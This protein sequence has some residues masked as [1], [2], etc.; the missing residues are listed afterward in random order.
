LDDQDTIQEQ[1]ETVFS[2][3]GCPRQMMLLA[4]VEAG[5]GEATLF[6]SLPSPSLLSAFEGFKQIGPNEL[7]ATASLLV[8]RNDEFRRHFGHPGRGFRP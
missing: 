3:L 2:K 4:A 8:G 6:L 5:T 1:A 7:P